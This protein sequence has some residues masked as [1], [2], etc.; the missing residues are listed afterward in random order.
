MIAAK[1]EVESLRSLFENVD[2]ELDIVNECITRNYADA[3][4]LTEMM[5][6]DRVF[7]VQK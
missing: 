7:R 2:S 4:D 6:V 1:K 5:Q 3:V